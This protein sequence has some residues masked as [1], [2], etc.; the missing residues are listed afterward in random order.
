MPRLSRPRP[1]F[2]ALATAL[3]LLA[4][5]WAHPQSAAVLPTTKRAD[6]SQSSALQGIAPVETHQQTI[7]L[8]P[9][10]SGLV[11]ELKRLD[12]KEEHRRLRVGFGRNF[13]E[14]VLVS[15]TTVPASEWTR[16]PDGGHA[17]ALDVTSDGALG[18]RLHIDSIVLPAGAKLLVYDPA[19]PNKTRAVIT[20][21][22]LAG[23]QEV[24][25]ESVFSP[26]AILECRLPPGLAPESV[27]FRVTGLSHFY[28]SIQPRAA[29]DPSIPDVSCDPDIACYP[30]W[31]AEGAGVALI[32]F[33]DSGST[34]LCT[35]CLL[36]DSEPATLI[37]YFLTAHHCITDRIVASTIEFFWFLQNQDC[38]ADDATNYVQTSG[39]ADLLAGSSI[40]DFAFMRLRQPSPA[41]VTY[42]GWSTSPPGATEQL[43]IIQHPAGFP[44]R[45]AFGHPSSFDRD[46]W[47]VGWDIGAT[48]EGS[49]GSPLLNSSKQLIG[50]LYGG[51][52][53]CSNP[54]GVDTF[55]RFD[56]TYK[57][58]KPWIDGGPFVS[59]KGTYNGLFYD[60]NGVIPQ[61]SG[62]VTVNVT[63]RGTFT[64]ALFTGGKRFSLNGSLDPKTGSG[65]KTISRPGATS[66]TVNLTLDFTLGAERM[67]GTVGDGTWLA[68]LVARKAVFDLR[69]NQTPYLGAYTLI[70]PGTN[71]DATLPSGHSYA[72]IKIDAAGKIRVAGSLADST[73]L[74]QNTTV[75]RD[76]SWALYSSLYGGK[77]CIL[78][79]L[80]VTNRH[81][82]GM[83]GQVSWF[84]Q[85]QARAKVSPGGFAYSPI[86]AVGSLYQPKFP[87]IS[88]TNSILVFAGTS[89]AL[90]NQ[91]TISSDN[92]IISQGT[93][94][95][96]LTISLLT[97]LISGTA[98]P[99]GSTRPAP[100]RG[101]VLQKANAAFGYCI[102]ANQSEGI[103]VG[104]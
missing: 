67:T 10:P 48:E 102:I 24:W 93:G 29:V 27:S 4:P 7:H 40:S 21:Q 91:A 61:S 66:L 43:A 69:T 79:W 25:T 35:G 54:T 90:T 16:L 15:P 96:N 31:L 57:S 87:S 20:A 47:Q 30:D 42:L 82:D 32:Q 89:G 65:S 6:I 36:N 56:V 46:F 1:R 49:S 103:S 64:G 37:D 18:V 104:Q 39:G 33:V 97:G 94:Q 78:G 26:R 28:R 41:G 100:V 95:A 8:A 72:G 3:L 53:S 17:W 74:N 70:I 85:P 77:G 71:G 22:T 14:P 45:I 98:T 23:E 63:T 73:A 58:I 101:A 76:G 80:Q 92:K 12:A 81:A 5:L 44:T 88:P 38:G 50:Q 68:Q 19:H 62:S 59:T 60:T 51:F 2:G 55:G 75:A 84:K 99:P 11:T 83:N 52:S 9:L 13:D 34:F 86:P